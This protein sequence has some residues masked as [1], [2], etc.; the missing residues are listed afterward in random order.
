M[1]SKFVFV[2]VSISAGKL[3]FSVGYPQIFTFILFVD[4]FPISI[5]LSKVN[6]TASKIA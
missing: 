2:S 5:K 4:T 6:P 1:F 3:L